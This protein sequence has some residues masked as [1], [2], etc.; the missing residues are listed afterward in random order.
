M[1]IGQPMLIHRATQEI[2]KSFDAM[3]EKI[4]PLGWQR[5]NLEDYN[6]RVYKLKRNV[7]RLPDDWD[8]L[9]EVNLTQLVIRCGCAFEVRIA[10]SDDVN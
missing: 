7:I 8:H 2:I 9:S 3:E 6:F 10:T 4:F 1:E 5:V